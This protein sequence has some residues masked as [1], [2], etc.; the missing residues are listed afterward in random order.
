L[1]GYSQHGEL[2]VIQ[3]AELGGVYAVSFVLVAANS[4]AA[5]LCML[6]WRRA[7]PGVA[8]ASG[9]VAATLAF[10]AMRLAAG[11]PRPAVRVGLIQPSIEQPLK[12]DPEHAAHPGHLRG[13]GAG[14]PPRPQILVWPETALP[15]PAPTPAPPTAHRAGAHAGPL[16]GHRRATPSPPVPQQRSGDRRRSG[17]DMIRSSSFPR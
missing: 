14:A 2:A 8:V 17:I 1:L 12:F 16:L 5:A 11:D 3:I 10:G 15:G 4:A 13:A 6:P 9:L 7:A